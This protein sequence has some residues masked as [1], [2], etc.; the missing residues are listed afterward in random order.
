MQLTMTAS[1][2]VADLRTHGMKISVAR[3]ID[4]FESGVYPFGRV[5]ST[6]KRR[7]VEIFSAEYQ[8]WL[9]KMGVSIG[10]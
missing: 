6:G 5:T 1:E 9:V 2:V 8:A 10:S 4:G 7:R 3:L